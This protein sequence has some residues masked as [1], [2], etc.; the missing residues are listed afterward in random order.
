MYLPVMNI[1][2]FGII[3]YLLS[4]SG[5]TYQDFTFWGIM[6]TVLVIQAVTTIHCKEKL[7]KE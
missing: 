5:I 3:A 2:C 1:V 4:E 7:A 6:I